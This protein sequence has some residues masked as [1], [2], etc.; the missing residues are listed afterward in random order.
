MFT[1]NAWHP[2][3][4]YARA[5]VV[6]SVRCGISGVVVMVSPLSQQILS[7]DGRRGKPLC[8]DGEA[9]L[10]RLARERPGSVVD[11][12][13]RDLAERKLLQ[14]RSDLRVGPLLQHRVA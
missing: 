11:H 10:R 6:Q 13:P 12:Q 3:W 7:H 4:F 14:G 2:S 1:A 5:V 8:Q 9:P